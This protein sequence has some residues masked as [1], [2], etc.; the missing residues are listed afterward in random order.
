MPNFNIRIALTKIKGAKVMDIEGK[1]S[2]RKCVVIPI[3]SELGTVQDS[4]EGK[5]DGM[6]TTRFLDD[7]QLNLTAFEFREPRYG[8]THGIKVAFSK[9]AMERMTEEE[10]RA[11]PFIG[12]LKPWAIHSN[13]DD[14]LPAGNESSGG[15][16]W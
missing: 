8:Q 6:P 4:Y 7:V 1:H 2:T 13:D 14:D 5:V 9:K 16:D 12:N 11:M 10:L 3:D 15:D